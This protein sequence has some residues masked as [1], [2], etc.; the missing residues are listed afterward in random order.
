MRKII[1]LLIG[2]LAF[3]TYHEANAITIN[4]TT[5]EESFGPNDWISID[6]KVNGYNG[7]PIKWTAQKPDNTV[8]SGSIEQVLGGITRHQII[9]DAFDNEFGTW[10]INYQYGGANKTVYAKVEPINLIVFL[11]KDTYYEPDRM[12]INVTTSYY[13]PQ[14]QNAQF[15]HLN[16]YDKKGNPAKNVDQIDIRVFQPNI[17]YSFWVRDITKYNPPGL[18]NLKI[19]Y[20][21]TIKQIPFL[22]GDIRNLMEI[23][24]NTLS[25][26]KQGDDLTFDMVFTRVKDLSGTLTITFPSGNSTTNIFSVNSVH[27]VSSI[28]N[29]TN[30]IGDY[31]FEIKYSG[32]TYDGSFKVMPNPHL[33]PNISL[34]LLLNKLNY[35][36]GEKVIAKV[37]TSDIIDSQIKSWTVD[38]QGMK[39]GEISIP[40]FSNDFVFP[41]KI[42]DNDS[43]GMWKFYVDYDGVVRTSTFYVSDSIQKDLFNQFD[44]PDLIS[45]MNVTLNSANGIV[46][47]KDNR[48]YVS[49]TGNSSIAKYDRNGNLLLSWGSY[50]SA[51]GQFRHPTGIFVNQKYV[52]VADTG[53]SRIEMFDKFGNFVYS[54]GS[55][56]TDHGMFHSPT[57][58]SSDSFGDLYVAD[59]DRNVIQI[60]D[61]HGNYIDQI[62]PVFTTSASF[63]GIKSLMFDSS[64][65]FYAVTTDNKVLKYSSIGNFINFYGSLGSEQGR[66]DNP[67]QVAV[68]SA[69]FLYVADTGNHRIQKFDPNGNF[70][71]EWGNTPNSTLQE[72]ISFA[73]DSSDNMFVVD[74]KRNNIQK[75]AL[76]QQSSELIFP[77]W[78]KNNVGWWAEGALDRKDFTISMRYLVNQGLIH[79]PSL[80]T[81]SDLQ[82]ESMQK[83][84]NW[85]KANGIMWYSGQIDDKTFALSMEYLLSKRIME[86]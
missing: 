2:F 73:I 37:H 40:V 43:V 63:T 18:Y 33:L 61:I 6:L 9:R 31:K 14:A 26:Y 58:I 41:Y 50:G 16:F 44:I 42:K 75:F 54:W 13:I 49:N 47:D 78:V 76:H 1:F 81:G 80:L 11:D 77:I 20:F 29:M 8:Q 36:R 48:I 86:I 68:D 30:E 82:V 52:Y 23:S 51:N 38:P 70:I 19:Q 15:Y 55:Y 79:S 84:P 56:G 83:I 34:D 72:P 22:V 3:A 85:V 64:D 62:Q 10:T 71:I 46:V 17:A 7:G 4:A 21:N 69:N 59:S 65:N 24:A 53:N 74:G 35:N 27:T 32:I 66:F 25:Q 12:K 39:H 5:Q 67:S 28:K 57:S 45:Q 60:F